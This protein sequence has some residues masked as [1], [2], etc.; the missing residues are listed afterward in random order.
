LASASTLSFTG[1]LDP[2][3]PNDVFLTS[4]T[5][6]VAGDV[7][8]QSWGYGGTSG[9]PGGTNAAGTV[10]AAGGFDSYVS[11]FLGS[12]PSATFLA[13]N[14]DG[15]CGP[16]TASPVCE[17]SRLDLASLAAGTYTL[18]LT[19]PNNFSFAENYG[20]GTLGDGFIGLQGDYYDFASE[21]LR[22]SAYAVDIGITGSTG[23]TAVTPEPPS[24]ILFATGLLF[25]SAVVLRRHPFGAKFIGLKF[26][27][28]FPSSF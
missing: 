19:L 28:Q 2:T 20:S 8:I 23:S 12:G 3:N 27:N 1:N 22:T 25:S 4:F 5:L 14:D 15:G 7:H 17:D 11:L 6:S 21:G 9:A 18:A 13:S 24:L 10:I 26:K 16:A